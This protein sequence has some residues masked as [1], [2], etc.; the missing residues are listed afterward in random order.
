MKTHEE[1]RT[2]LT[3]KEIEQGRGNDPEFIE[4]KSHIMTLEC[5]IDSLLNDLE[6]EIWN[7]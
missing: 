1:L 2:L 4:L 3:E 6:R 5:K 7:D